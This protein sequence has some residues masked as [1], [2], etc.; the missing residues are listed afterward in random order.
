LANLAAWP[1]RE[2]AGPDLLDT[3]YGHLVITGD[4]FLEA[5]SLDGEVREL[6]GM[7]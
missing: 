3:C 4:A 1:N 6:V 7:G 2:Q 5:V